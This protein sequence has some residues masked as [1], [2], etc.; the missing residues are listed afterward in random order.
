MAD[1]GPHA[2]RMGRRARHLYGDR[3]RPVVHRS[4]RRARGGRGV[5]GRRRRSSTRSEPASATRTSRHCQGCRRPPSG[6][7]ARGP[8]SVPPTDGSTRAPASS[9]PRRRTSTPR[10]PRPRSLR[11]PSAG[12]SSSS[13]RGRSGSGRGSSSTTTQRPGGVGDPRDGARRVVVNNNPETVSTDYDACTR[14]Y[15]E[16]LDTESVLDVIDHE[17]AL[18]GT[19]PAVVLTFGGQTAI[20]LAKDLAYADVPIAGLS[21]EAIEVTEDRSGSPAC[22][23]SLGWKGLADRSRPTRPGCEA[24]STA[25]AGCRHRPPIVGYRRPRIAVLRDDSDVVRY[26]ATDVGWPLRVDELVAG[27][28]PTSTPSA[29]GTA[30]RC[31]ASSSSSTCRE[32]TPATAS[33][34]SRRRH[35]R[36]RC[37]SAAGGRRSHRARPRGAG[38]PQRPDDRDRGPDRGHRGEPTGQPD[39]CP[40]SPKRRARRRGRCR[41]MRSARRWWTSG[42]PRGCRRRSARR[43]QGADRVALAPP[44]R[45]YGARARDA[46]D[47]RGAR[48]G[49]GG[50]RG[51]SAGVRG[52]CRARRLS[53]PG[54]PLGWPSPLRAG[55]VL[56]MRK[57]RRAPVRRVLEPTT[58]E[59]RRRRSVRTRW[60]RVKSRPARA[61]SATGPIRGSALPQYSRC[62]R[63]PD[64]QVVCPCGSPSELPLAADVGCDL[65]LA[66]AEIPAVPAAEEP[67]ASLVGGLEEQLRDHTDRR[68]ERPRVHA[69]LGEAEEDDRGGE[70]VADERRQ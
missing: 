27:T 17:R 63:R 32:C 4:D 9:L 45:P 22:S 36:D 62:L 37:R 46:L 65:R 42:S 43:G 24:P 69:L 70:D 12:A 1:R 44:G 60:S 13:A 68:A 64:W 10:T 6:A 47:G 7:P 19:P 41:S 15:F 3:H 38:H 23:P 51:A 35:S 30:G 11:R 25:S 18:T 67:E 39:R 54:R 50:R 2:P 59:R 56:G 26:L 53:G 31:R 14:L 8:A 52:G 34:S 29:T 5:R 28:E 66:A 48:P 20:D 33:R 49:D 21:A 16:P 61:S 57:G 58:R 55:P 40:S